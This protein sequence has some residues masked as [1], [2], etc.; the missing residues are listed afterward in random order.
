MS[1]QSFVYQVNDGIATL[2]LNDPD[3]LNA[4]TFEVYAELEQLTGELAQDEPLR[5]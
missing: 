5:S 1:Y 2:H 3:V 4:L